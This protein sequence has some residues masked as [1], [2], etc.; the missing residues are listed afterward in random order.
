MSSSTSSQRGCGSA[1]ITGVPALP[2]VRDLAIEALCCRS[3]DMPDVVHSGAGSAGTLGQ[4]PSISAGYEIAKLVRQ[5]QA[6]QVQTAIL[7]LQQALCSA[8][9]PTPNSGKLLLLQQQLAMH[10][11]AQQAALLA[12]N[13]APLA[14][15]WPCLRSEGAQGGVNVSGRRKFHG[16]QA[17]ACLQEWLYSNI[18]NPY[19]SLDVKRVLAR[20]SGLSEIQVDHWF[21]NAR[22]RLLKT[23]KPKKENID[24]DDTNCEVLESSSPRMHGVETKHA[25]KATLQTS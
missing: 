7:H 9:L 13:T 11:P 21:N 14:S 19:P 1:C 15:P 17:V 16:K 5:L 22:K 3:E 8:A 24:P 6:L 18:K 2:L 10:S 4:V 20:M 23:R 12:I 25:G